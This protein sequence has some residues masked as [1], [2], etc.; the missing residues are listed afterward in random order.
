[1][2]KM[3]IKNDTD[4][5]LIMENTF[6]TETDADYLRRQAPRAFLIAFVLFSAVAG[7]GLLV[8]WQLF[9]FLEMIVLLSCLVA[10][11]VK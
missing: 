5:G 11:S 6:Y 7:L 4:K 9:A 2:S 1:M 3:S 8:S 10:F